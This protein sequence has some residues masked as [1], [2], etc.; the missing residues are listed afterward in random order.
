MSSSQTRD[1]RPG[2][3]GQGAQRRPSLG[4]IWLRIGLGFV[5][6]ILLPLAAG[7][8]FINPIINH[9]G[10]E[11][12]Q[13][14]YAVENPGETLLIDGLHY[15]WGA[16]R[17]SGHSLTWTT[18]QVILQID[19]ATLHNVRWFR[20]LQGSSPGEVLAKANLDAEGLTLE[21][22][23][24]RH[25]VQ[26]RRLRVSVPDSQ[27][28]AEDLILSPLV[29]E[30]AEG[31]RR[32]DRRL[33]S[34]FLNLVKIRESNEPDAVRP[35]VTGEVDFTR[36]PENTFIQFIWFALRSGVLDVIGH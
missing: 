34:F 6:L 35:M 26:C 32:I 23:R 30:Q 2:A 8:L 24:Q 31:R 9:Y 29:D 16:N 27:F 1:A 12:I 20:L 18:P 22:P 14:A 21:L 17:L 3:R 13:R 4:R 36:E 5:C 15:S 10:K 28:L 11:R 7:I 19:K 25:H 33:A